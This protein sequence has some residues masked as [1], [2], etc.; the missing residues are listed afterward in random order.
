LPFRSGQTLT[1]GSATLILVTLIAEQS[2]ANGN[3]SFRHSPTTN[4]GNPTALYAILIS[5]GVNMKKSILL[6]LFL[7]AGYP[8]FAESN[9]NFIVTAKS[10]LIL[11]KESTIKSK[12]LALI[13]YGTIIKRINDFKKE[14]SETLSKIFETPVNYN[15]KFHSEYVWYNTEFNGIIGYAFSYF[16]IPE[17]NENR[18]HF[19]YKYNKD[20]ISIIRDFIPHSDDQ[21]RKNFLL[22]TKIYKNNENLLNF[23]S[24]IEIDKTAFL[25]DL[26]L[27]SSRPIEGS[28]RQGVTCLIFLNE[29][30]KLT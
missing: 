24:P 26:H 2:R 15:G 13:P 21:D 10:G 6:T 9:S 29:L 7:L 14:D 22:V 27:Y 12:K 17:T 3:V 19:L 18:N 5:S 1:T 20:N 8:I 11:R 4:V 16:L 30:S 28:E 25:D 23:E